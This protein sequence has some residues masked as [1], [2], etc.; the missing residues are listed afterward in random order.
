MWLLNL[1]ILSFSSFWSYC[2]VN[3]SKIAI[4]LP[5]FLYTSQLFSLDTI[6]IISYSIRT[7]LQCTLPSFINNISFATCAPFPIS[8][9]T[10]LYLYEIFIFLKPFHTY[11]ILMYNTLYIMY[12]LHKKGPPLMAKIPYK[13]S[14]L[15]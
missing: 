15:V 14:C 9:K 3:I 12:T 1:N 5:L 10:F 13:N 2:T 6:F 11:I 4:F 7:L 8:Q